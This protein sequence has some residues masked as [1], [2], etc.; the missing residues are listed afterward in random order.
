MLLLYLGIPQVG[1][2]VRRFLSIGAN[3][4]EQDYWLHREVDGYCP[5]REHSYTDTHHLLI[6]MHCW[7]LQLLVLL[8]VLAAYLS[9]RQPCM[10]ADRRHC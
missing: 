2:F 6:V 10:F 8:H 3:P 5:Q 4:E 1:S 9:R 7:S